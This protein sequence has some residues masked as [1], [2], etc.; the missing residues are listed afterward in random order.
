MPP[1]CGTERNER[2]HS[3]I[4]RSLLC[5]VSKIGPELALAVM[6]CALIVCLELQTTN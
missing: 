6:S 5:G 4:N 3:H 1:G 2:L